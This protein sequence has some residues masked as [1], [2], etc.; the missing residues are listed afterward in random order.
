MRF[1]D[2]SV[3]RVPRKLLFALICASSLSACGNA[4]I[5]V[6]SG[7]STPT[8]TPGLVQV[9]DH[10]VNF[11]SATYSGGLLSVRTEATSASPVGS[12]VG[13]GTGNKSIAGLPMFDR[14]P[15]SSLTSIS[16]EAKSIAGSGGIYLNLIVDLDCVANEDFS[17]ASFTIANARSN[18]KILLV[19]LWTVTALDDGY[20]SYS[21]AA[22]DSRW[23]AVGGSGGLPG[24]DPGQPL[25]TFVA[26]YP[27]ACILNGIS[28]DGGVGRA[29]GTG[30]QTGAG[31]AT[32]APGYCGKS[33]SGVLFVLGGST[34]LSLSEWAIRK[35]TVNS[36]ALQ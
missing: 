31:L 12:Y 8:P 23:L 2:G 27:N 34:S 24:T 36:T 10:S 18:R 19:D 21:V 29:V 14:L 4:K 13:G 22:T 6:V 11:A 15:L 7:G 20:S 3:Q 25:S 9:I 16:Y 1:K 17:T 32:S 5:E 35:I 26:S 30:C 28:A 33:A